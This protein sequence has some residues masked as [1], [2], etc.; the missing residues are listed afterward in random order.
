MTKFSNPEWIASDLIGQAE[1]DSLAQC[2]LISKDKLIIKKVND[3]INKQL[4]NLPRTTIAKTSLIGNGILIYMPS[5][6]K[7]IDT[8]NKI[9]PEHLELKY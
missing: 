6:K 2:I 9:A 7:I 5:D 3:E 4:K 8:V 1:H